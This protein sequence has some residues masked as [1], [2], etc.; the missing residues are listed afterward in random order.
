MLALGAR[1]VAVGEHRLALHA[2]YRPLAAM[3]LHEAAANAAAAA[4]MDAATRL[5]THVQVRGGVE[6]CR[7]GCVCNWG[8]DRHVFWLGGAFVSLA[9]AS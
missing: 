1:L 5:A 3:A 9:W 7:V 4:R 8:G 6:P 2:A